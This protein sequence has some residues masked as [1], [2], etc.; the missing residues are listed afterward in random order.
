MRVPVSP[1]GLG[2]A[3]LVGLAIGLARRRPRRDARLRHAVVTGGSRGLG[4]ALAEELLARGVRVSI[5]GRDELALA[6]AREALVERGEVRAVR[7]DLADPEQLDRFL[8]EAREANGPV[9]LLVNNAAV[10][11]VGPLE[12]T[13]YEDYE[14]TLRINFLAPLRLVLAVLPEMRERRFGRIVNICSVGGRV[15]MPHLLPY[16]ASKFALTGFSEGLRAELAGTGVAVTTVCPGLTRTGS[17]RHAE[18]RGRPRA[19]HSWF[20]VSDSL[21]VLSRDARSTARRIVDAAFRGEADVL[22][23][24]PAHLATPLHAFFPGLT[25]DVLGLMNRFL[26]PRAP[27]EGA[28]SARGRE[29]RSRW[30]PSLLTR[31]GDRA[32]RELNQEP[33]GPGSDEPVPELP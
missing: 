22:T 13:H 23:T 5:C 11:Q 18:F 25:A 7:A 12:T 10:I 32:A 28:D 33:A 21:P 14:R 20:A 31:L 19:E 3:A 9:D 16:S 24:L 2:A 26:L 6:R 4:Y 27:A 1:A 30:A 15:S 17:P 8:R 29:S